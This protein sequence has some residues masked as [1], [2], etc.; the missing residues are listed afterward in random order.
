MVNDKV[1]ERIRR[2]RQRMLRMASAARELEKILC[3]NHIS[4]RG[5]ATFR[6]LAEERRPDAE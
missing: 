3:S 1:L 6:S 5:G 2:K 4:T